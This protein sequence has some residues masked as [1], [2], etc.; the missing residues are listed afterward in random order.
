MDIEA[1]RRG[2]ETPEV[3]DAAGAQAAAADLAAAFVSDPVFD[4]F[5]R[6]DGRRAAARLDFFRFLVRELVTGVG[7]VRRPAA[8]GA[9]AIWMPSESLGPN[10]LIKEIQALPMLLALTGWSRFYR[11]L[12]LREVM[13]KHHP[14]DR[15]H[16][17]LWFLGVTPEAQ[18]HGVGSRLLKSHLDHLD[19]IGRPAFLETA[20]E[21]NLRLY[22]R[23]G[24]QVIAEYRPGGDGPVNW[25]MWRDPQA[26]E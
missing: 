2:A 9:A 23:H 7:Q 24:F 5:T 11:L 3:A 14:L 10:P 17:Y 19:A 18:G 16:E 8:G 25:A 21:P 6:T 22:G 4:W 15:P 1:I 12:Q 20:T 26:A 13:D